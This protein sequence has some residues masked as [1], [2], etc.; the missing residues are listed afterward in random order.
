MAAQVGQLGPLPSG[1]YTGT[2]S[3]ADIYPNHVGLSGLTT[4]DRTLPAYGEL[5]AAAARPGKAL[6]HALLGTPAG[7]LALALLA[8]A[9]LAWYHGGLR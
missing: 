3:E 7:Y 1:V 6:E 2:M 8:L 9:A 5:T 4:P